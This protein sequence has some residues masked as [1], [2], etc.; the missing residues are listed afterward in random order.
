MSEDIFYKLAK[1]FYS[2]PVRWHIIGYDNKIINKGFNPDKNV[3]ITG[4]YKS[5]Q[6]LIDLVKKLEIDLTVFPSICPETYSFTLTESWSCG[7]PALVSNIG[8]LEERVRESMGGWAVYPDVDHFKEKI[9]DILSHPQ[10]YEDVQKNL[11]KVKLKTM[12]EMLKNYENLYFDIYNSKEFSKQ[13]I[14]K[15]PK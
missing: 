4:K 8:A 13:I 6:E 5:T 7:I 11:R 9:D 10:E 12:N 15:H 3:N 14:G 1:S 2:K